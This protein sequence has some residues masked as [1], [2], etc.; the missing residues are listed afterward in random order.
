LLLLEQGLAD[1]VKINM[2]NRAFADSNSSR[3]Q[4]CVPTLDARFEKATGIQAHDAR[5]ADTTAAIATLSPV[6][7]R[8]RQQK[9]EIQHL[10][11]VL[12]SE[13]STNTALEA[14]A[15]RHENTVALSL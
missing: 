15:F 8:Y 6:T 5:L 12:S 3:L 9:L 14:P 4:S 10:P 1:T 13:I 11:P 7:K 2:L